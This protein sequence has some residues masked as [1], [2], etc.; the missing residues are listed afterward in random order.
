MDIQRLVNDAVRDVYS[1]VPV[2][3]TA[4]TEHE[5][6]DSLPYPEKFLFNFSVDLLERYHEALLRE[7][8]Q[9]GIHL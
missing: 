6:T 1:S 7:L 5:Y 3:E 8:S 4:G 9:Q 2:S